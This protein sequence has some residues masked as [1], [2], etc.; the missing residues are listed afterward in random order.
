MQEETE[1][2]P[3]WSNLQ[4][5]SLDLSLFIP[6]IPVDY[7]KRF[8][9]N[10]VLVPA[11]LFALVAMIWAMDKDAP[12]QGVD[13]ISPS[14]LARRNQRRRTQQKSDY[15]FAFFVVY[16]TLSK[17]F[18]DH[19]DCRTLSADLS[20]LRVDNVVTCY[21]GQWTLFA[22]FAGFG[23]VVVSF[24]LPLFLLFIMRKAMNE[25]VRQIRRGEKKAV[26]AFNEFGADFDYVVGN[27]KTEAYYAE[28]LDL[29]KKLLLSGMIMFVYP[30]ECQ[31]AWI[32][33]PS[34]ADYF[35]CEQAQSCN[36]LLPC[37]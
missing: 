10:T 24:G 1:F 36:A 13:A 35:V 31:H 19:F 34:F 16:P 29:I 11:F 18:F 2:P 26:V 9:A 32:I 5:V 22:G 17:T 33:V 14:E 7:Y 4:L 28:S 21:D 20:I 8:I 37:L 27:Y 15:Y 12:P 25:K 3:S 23:L 30:G 6:C